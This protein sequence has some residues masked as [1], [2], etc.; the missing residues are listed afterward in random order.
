MKG[1]TYLTAAAILCLAPPLEAGDR[2]RLLA[3][4]TYAAATSGFSDSV[5]FTEFAEE[6]RIDSRYERGGGVGVDLGLEVFFTRHLGVHAAFSTA[7]REASS[8]YS[9]SLPHPFFFDQPREASGE[10]AGLGQSEIALH[11]DAVA[12]GGKGAFDCAIFGGATLF[13]V[14]SDLIETVRYDHGYPYDAVTVTGTNAR[15]FSENPVGFNLGGR[16]DYRFGRSRRFG[17]GAI[18]RY[19]RATVTITR[20]IGDSLGFDAGGFQAGLGLRVYF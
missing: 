12:G 7:S 17:V 6:G 2:F 4:G 14:D 15:S 16:V 8:S 10:E 13:R 3:S 11:L 18:A 19:S 20:G 1:P 9:A 5:R